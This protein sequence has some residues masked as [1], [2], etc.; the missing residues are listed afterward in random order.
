MLHDRQVEAV[1]TC[2]TNVSVII[3]SSL[4][5]THSSSLSYTKAWIVSLGLLAVKCVSLNL[6]L[7]GIELD[8][9]L[10]LDDI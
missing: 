3:T 7:R 1:C 6:A 8:L 10:T 5:S 9:T 4:L 2:L